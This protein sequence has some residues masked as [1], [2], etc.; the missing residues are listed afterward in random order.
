MVG[1]HHIHAV[2]LQHLHLVL[3]SDAVVHRY[4]QVGLVLKGT[5]DG[6]LRQAI[7]FL[8]AQRDEGRHLRPA[9][10]QALGHKRSGGNTVQI[11]VTKH[12][13]A[14]FGLDGILDAVHR[15]IHALY[16]VRVQ[17]IPLKGGVQEFPGLFNGID[18]P[19]NQDGGNEVGEPQIGC[20]PISRS[21]IGRSDVDA[22]THSNTYLLLLS[23]KYCKG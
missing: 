21:R 13:D 20:K 19:A 9:G 17:P 10:S 8:E 16:L 11:E 14:L 5:L 23:S 7:A 6:G 3:G 4:Q 2:C 22:R 15:R 12:Q 1:D 18:A